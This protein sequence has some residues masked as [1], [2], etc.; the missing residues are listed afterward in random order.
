MNTEKALAQLGITTNHLTSAQRKQFDED[1][2]FI[3][4][5]VFTAAEVTEMREAAVAAAV[6]ATGAVL[7]TA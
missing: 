6:K 2:F 7:R 4:D 1:G 5:N 3:V